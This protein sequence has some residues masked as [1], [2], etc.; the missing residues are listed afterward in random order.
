MIETDVVV[1]GAG[2][3]GSTAAKH[4]ALGGANVILIDKKSEIGTPK[5]CAEGIYDRGLKWLGIEPNPRWIA[6]TIR[7][8]ILHSYD[9]SS[10][11]LDE[12]ILPEHGYVLERKVF[13]K[14]M[15]MD[16]ARAGAKIMIKT[17]A[18]GLERDGDSYILSCEKMG[19][20]FQIKAKIV[21]GAD[22]PESRV[23]KWAGINTTTKP[24]YM[25][26]GAQFEMCNVD[27]VRDDLLEFYFDSSIAPGGYGWIFPK[28]N[29]VA[30]VGLG[31][32][33]N[34]KNQSAYEALVHFVKNCPATQNAQ[35]V[36]LNI[37]GD[38]IDGL[39]ERIY[40]DNLMLCGDAAGQV[41]P[42]EG[43]GIILGM[44]GGMAAGKTAAEAIKEGNYSKERLKQ[45]EIDFNES[46]Y[47]IVPKLPVARD[48]VLSLTDKDF[49]KIINAFKDEDLVNM[50]VKGFL[51]V[52]I[53]KLPRLSLKVT[54]L[55][56]MFLP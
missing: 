3:A 47:G 38:P 26:S 16:A 23:G 5:R 13:D 49:A 42:I 24:K 36:E 46:M 2:P 40:D 32:S 51:K 39:V 14:F 54:K 41:N 18:K 22:G 53:T 35:A 55:F 21:I 17:L 8:G 6:Q 56:K 33:G 52:F 19:E 44:M 1:V 50:D 25:M 37:G 12:T 48:F 28:G 31:I 4:A 15:A 7:G 30:N 10:I 29:G 9:G 20:E 43:G 45:Y 27:L 34:T 11:Q